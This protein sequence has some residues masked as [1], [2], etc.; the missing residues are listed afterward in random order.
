M[1]ENRFLNEI[2]LNVPTALHYLADSVRCSK[3]PTI[4]WKYLN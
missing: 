1:S 4:L 3:V 2:A